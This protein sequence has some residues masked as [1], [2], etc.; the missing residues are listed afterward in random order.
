MG[1]TLAW[2]DNHLPA[3]SALSRREREEDLPVSV[4]VEHLA[5]VSRARSPHQLRAAP[6]GRDLDEP[7]L[8][9]WWVDAAGADELAVGL[10]FPVEPGLLY[11][12]Q[13]GATHW[14]S[15]KRSGNTLRARLIGM[16][17]GGRAAMS[18]FRRTLAAALTPVG[19]PID[20]PAITAWMEAHLRV[21]AVPV[22]DADALA[23][24]E[25]QVLEQLDPPFNLRHM[26]PSDV[27]R[28]LTR[29][30]SAQAR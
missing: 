29:R 17:L 28:E 24:V 1:A 16:H 23:E 20:E 14:P 2:Y 25:R 9:T 5:D 4:L 19:S 12:G 13:A 6:R 10:G 27:R 18:T 26:A 8:Y 7:G 11:A 30:R 15:G 22:P 21:V 3:G